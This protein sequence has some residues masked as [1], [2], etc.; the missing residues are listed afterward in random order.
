MS[1]CTLGCTR[2]GAAGC[3]QAQGTYSSCSSSCDPCGSVAESSAQCSGVL[4][5]VSIGVW[6]STSMARPFATAFGHNDNPT[7]GSDCPIKR[8][9]KGANL[10]RS[11]SNRPSFRYSGIY[12]TIEKVGP[13][14]DGR[15]GILREYPC[16]R[17]VYDNARGVEGRSRVP[18]RRGRDEDRSGRM[19]GAALIDPRYFPLLSIQHTMGLAPEVP[20]GFLNLSGFRITV[21]SLVLRRTVPASFR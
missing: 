16:P 17:R 8:R 15:D 13:P 1:S 3:R 19:H 12:Q 14:R 21:E 7:A 2:R 4:A 5:V 20:A 10:A 6:R 18:S 11:P 9:L